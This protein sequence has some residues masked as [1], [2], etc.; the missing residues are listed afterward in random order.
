L[1]YWIGRTL[2]CIFFKTI[3]RLKILGRNNIPHD[4]IIVAANH[5][6]LLDPP[7]IGVVLPVGL[8]FMAKKELFNKKF[9]SWILRKV[10]AFPVDRKKPGPSSIK[11]ALGILKQRK[12][13]LIFPEGSRKAAG[14]TNTGVAYIAHKSQKPVVPVRIINNDRVKKLK[15]LKVV[16][17]LPVSYPAA[18]KQKQS[19]ED[20]LRFTEKI[21]NS[22]YSLFG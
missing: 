12:A 1:L 20:Y 22:I 16:I 15:R 5:R 10:H 18:A 4:G 2:Y 21:L 19:Q 11:H 7:L 6:S 9:F 3:F 8:Y 17:G 13:L 14:R